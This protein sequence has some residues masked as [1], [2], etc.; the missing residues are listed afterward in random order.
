MFESYLIK[1]LVTDRH[2]NFGRSVSFDETALFE[3][4]K[5]R[6]K[7]KE[8]KRLSLGAAVVYARER[9]RVTC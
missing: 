4:S 5:T 6:E 1:P 9:E 2:G 3:K 8:T 7:C